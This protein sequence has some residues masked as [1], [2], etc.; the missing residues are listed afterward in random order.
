MKQWKTL[1]RED[2]LDCGRFLKVEKHSVGLPDGTV[3]PNWSWVV[4]PDYV[5]V[6]AITAEGKFLCFRQ[7]KYAIE[8]DTL[9]LVGGFIEPG[10]DPLDAI[11]RELLE[12]TGY[13]SEEW[14][15]LGSY[16]VDPNRFVGKAH[17][18]MARNACRHCEPT[19]GDQEEHEL[20]ILERSEIQEAMRNN[21]FKALSWTA[22]LALALNR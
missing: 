5:N 10:E 13:V 6:V 14:L 12:E 17:F 9:A 15:E 7:I 16:V 8:G 2:I 1:T 4:T 18:F 19:A 11:K 22:A 20:I 3:I 21:Q